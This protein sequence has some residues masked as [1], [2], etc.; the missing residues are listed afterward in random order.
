MQLITIGT[1]NQIVLPKEVRNKIKGLKPGEKVMIYPLNEDTIA[2]K[3]DS[4][5]WVEKTKGS[6]KDA[7]KGIDTTAYLDK[8]RN[9]WNEK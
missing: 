9:E 7:W 3:L 5:N 2:I 4:K 1:K 6:M 8:L